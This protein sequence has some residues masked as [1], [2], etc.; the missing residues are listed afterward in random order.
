[1]NKRLAGEAMIDVEALGAEADLCFAPYGVGGEL[2]G[3]WQE[4]HDLRPY[5]EKFAALV[6]EEAAR[7]AERAQ[8]NQTA[9]ANIAAA[10]R[11]L[12]PS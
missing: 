1:M 10:V 12:K 5:M 2:H 9:C 7:V 4:D 6:L 11:A 8:A 3:K